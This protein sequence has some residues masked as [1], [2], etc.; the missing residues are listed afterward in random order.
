ML[1]REWTAW[2][3]G[4]LPPEAR[5]ASGIWGAM[6]H[7]RRPID[8]RGRLAIRCEVTPRDD[9]FDLTVACTGVARCPLQVAFLFDPG[10]AFDLSPGLQRTGDGSFLLTEGSAT[11]RQAEDCLEVSGSQP[12]HRIG[13]L[14]GDEPCSGTLNLLI[15]AVAPM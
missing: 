13:V 1:E 9:G 15:N 3:N 5:V 12:S 10:G 14:R 2:D 8:H 6:D 7:A 11:F 4:P